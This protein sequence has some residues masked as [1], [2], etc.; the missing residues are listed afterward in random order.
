MLVGYARSSTIEQEAGFQAQIKAL[1]AAW[2]REGLCRAGLLGS[3]AGAAR[4]RS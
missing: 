1:K 3:Q 2:L 4:G